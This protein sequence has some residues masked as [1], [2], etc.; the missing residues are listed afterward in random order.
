MQ[1]LICS[2]LWRG[3]PWALN[4]A[5]A[6]ACV[7]AVWAFVASAR[8]LG[9]RDALL[10]GFALA[11]TPVFF[12]NSVT[13]KDYLWA[14]A[15]VLA[16]LWSVLDRR[17]VLAGLLLGLAGGCRITSLAMALPL[18]LILLGQME[19]ARGGRELLAFGLT[20]FTTTLVVFAP[21][22][23]RYGT[24]FLTFYENH[25]RPGWESIV[26]HAGREVWGTVLLLAARFAPQFAF[27]IGCFCLTIS[28]WLE[29]GPGGMRPGAILAD[30]RARVLNLRNVNSCLAFAEKMS[31]RNVIVVGAW[32]PQIAVLTAGQEP[33]RNRYVYLLDRDGATAAVASGDR[34][35]YLPAI[36][37]FNA[38]INGNDLAEVGRDLFAFYQTEAARAGSLGKNAP[39]IKTKD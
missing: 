31:G 1:E 26:S 10:A 39:A 17:S 36:R 24:G 33:L 29:I 22:W 4:G 13:S 3:G 30:H 12:V 7:A 23:L 18:A 25:S 35:L 19:K 38:Q 14:L 37:A 20:T 9:C 8:R 2:W 28:P 21:V 5:S 6:L 32:E 16:S 11:M 27:Q 34:I 15:F